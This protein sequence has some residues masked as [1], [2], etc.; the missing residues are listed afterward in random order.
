MVR[1]KSSLIAAMSLLALFAASALTQ[2][3]PRSNGPGINPELRQSLQNLG[4]EYKVFDDGSALVMV[5]TEHGTIPIA[6]S[7]ERTTENGVSYRVL[8]APVKVYDGQGPVDLNVTLQ[9]INQG[10]PL[11]RLITHQENGKTLVCYMAPLPASP[12]TDLLR[13]V[14]HDAARSAAQARH[15]LTI[16]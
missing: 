1:I 7:P 5:P 2:A 10:L 8:M 9:R 11:A 15:D 16:A 14:L 13:T 6:L 12:T 4:Y 3:Q